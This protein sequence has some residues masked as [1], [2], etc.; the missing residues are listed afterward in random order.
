VVESCSIG[1]KK[2]MIGAKTI[3]EMVT[4]SGIIRNSKSIK[5]EIIKT[6]KR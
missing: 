2:L 4:S 5:V 1:N 3:P 6:L